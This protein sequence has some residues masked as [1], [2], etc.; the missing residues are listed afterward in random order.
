MSDP[1]DITSAPVTE[2]ESVVTGSYL[3][4]RRLLDYDGSL[5]TLSYDLIPRVTGTTITVTGTWDASAEEWQF[6]VPSATSAAWAAGSYRWDLKVT[7]DSDSEVIKIAT[8]SIELFASTDDR[9][10][11]AE[12]M[13]QKIESILSGRADS[14]VDSYSI[15]SRSITKMSVKELTD[16]RDYYRDE[17]RRTGGSVTGSD[18]PKANKVRVRWV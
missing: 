13:V 1:F 12:I 4:W 8:G 15:K 2:P 3:A 16:W 5:F 6:T 7:R 17:V 14:D 11:H 18:Q 9:R 10:T